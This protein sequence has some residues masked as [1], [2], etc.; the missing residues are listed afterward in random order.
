V[1][2][3]VR[4]TTFAVNKALARLS[5]K[6]CKE[7]RAFSP[8]FF[9]YQYDLDVRISTTPDGQRI[10]AQLLCTVR[11]MQAALAL[12][13]LAK[14]QRTVLKIVASTRRPSLATRRLGRG[15]SHGSEGVSGADKNVG[16]HLKDSIEM[17]L[18]GLHCAG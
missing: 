2:L 12:L 18:A 5:A 4:A 1:S 11:L 7:S 15:W 17:K 6:I 16:V 9:K 10:P 13:S 8:V 3:I 14:I